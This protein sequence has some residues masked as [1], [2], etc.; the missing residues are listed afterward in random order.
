MFVCGGSAGGYTVLCCLTN[1]PD[2][3]KA[4]VSR[5]GICDMVALADF[6]HKFELHYMESLMGGSKDKIYQI[7]FDRSPVHFA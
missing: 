5:Y 7:Y 6:T 2:V 1:R 3:F 4:G